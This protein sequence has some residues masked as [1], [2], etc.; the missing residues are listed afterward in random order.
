MQQRHAPTPWV[1]VLPPT[2]PLQNKSP[3]PQSKS[4]PST[5]C[6]DALV[7]ELT[8]RTL[9]HDLRGGL[10]VVQGWVEVAALDGQLN[11]PQLDHSIAAL[12]NTLATTTGT[13]AP[14][15]Q[16]PLVSTE[17]LL[18]DLPGADLPTVGSRVHVCPE[19]FRVAMML[20]APV[21]VTVLAHSMSDR[22]V[23]EVSGLSKEGVGQACRPSL[24]RLAELRRTRCDDR[25]LG[26]IL[27]RA[28]A[29]SAGGHVRSVGEG[30]I[31]LH[32]KGETD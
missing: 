27:L 4:P 7:G 17:T 24:P 31:E 11:S 1:T 10:G 20:A 23:L 2:T 21:A 3:M 25:T 15:S 6:L 13:L 29:A 19:R 22:V 28:V 30:T 14:M 12:A 26:A 18:K 9:L 32:L 16:F 8:L 5:I